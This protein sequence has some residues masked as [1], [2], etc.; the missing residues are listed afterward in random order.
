MH[1]S[2]YTKQKNVN[3]LYL[4]HTSIL[5]HEEATV[6]GSLDRETR[7]MDALAFWQI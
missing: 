6:L 3:A 7:H 1:F 5:L 4:E 2:P